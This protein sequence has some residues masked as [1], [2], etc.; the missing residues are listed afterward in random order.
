[1]SA[2]PYIGI[3]TT[4]YGNAGIWLGGN[5]AGDPP[6]TTWK[7]SFY[8]DAN[9]YLLWDGAKLTIKAANFTLDA[10]GKITATSAN[11]SGSITSSSG[12]IGGWTINPTTLSAANITLDSTGSIK[13]NYTA[14][15]TGWSINSAGDAEFNNVVIRATGG[16][17][18]SVTG[19]SI[20]EGFLQDSAATI[21]LDA[22]NKKITVGNYVALGSNVKTANYIGLKITDANY[23]ET[24]G[25][26]TNF[27][28]GTKLSYTDSSG[29]GVLSV[30]G[31]VK[32]TSGYIGGSSSGW[33]IATN[34][35]YYG[36]SSNIYSI[37][38]DGNNTRIGIH[39][40]ADNL[41]SIRLGYN[42]V[43]SGLHGLAFYNSSTSLNNYWV[44]DTNLSKIKFKVGDSTN[45]LDFN[46]GTAS[47]LTIKTDTFNLATTNLTID[48]AAEKIAMGSIV[49]QGSA[50][51]YIGIGTTSYSGA[52]IWLGK[53]TTW[54]ASFYADANN[55]LKWTGS[56]LDINVNAGVFRVTTTGALTATN[57]TITGNITANSGTIAGWT[58]DGGTLKNGTGIVLNAT[59]QQITISNGA[60]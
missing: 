58:I 34:E 21:K 11:I 54:K 5:T 44:W 51:P 32:A 59:A 56:A 35:L 49:L 45:Y 24:N 27:A 15:S 12:T 23:W 48:S 30:E 14:G 26:Y 33:H 31:E 40:L 50:S 18:G 17:L 22:A 55:Y 10:N 2:S 16:T 6:V 19:W 41:P 36:T 52:G 60:I 39:S 3:G 42:V 1:G 13:A 47:K 57:A 7:A 46:V 28:L 37:K 38:L 29:T 9:N 43:S 25:T 53:D 20:Q 4:T 8:A